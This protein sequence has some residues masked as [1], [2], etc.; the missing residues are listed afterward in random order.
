MLF[1]FLVFADVDSFHSSAQ[2]LLIFVASALLHIVL[3]LLT[4]AEVR[5]QRKPEGF[6]HAGGLKSMLA[7]IFADGCC[8][9]MY[10]YINYLVAL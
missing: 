3:V 9:S 8:I 6:F 2:V 5:Q 4:K 10:M 1:G 7:I